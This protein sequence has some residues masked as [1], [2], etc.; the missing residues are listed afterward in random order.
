MRTS[1]LLIGMLVIAGVVW[2]MIGK[3][4]YDFCKKRCN[5]SITR[6]LTTIEKIEKLL[7]DEDN[8]KNLLEDEGKGSEEDDYQNE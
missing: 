1:N 2:L 6:E 3:G 8:E 5:E 7:A 4:K